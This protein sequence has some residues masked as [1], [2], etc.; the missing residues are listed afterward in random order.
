MIKVLLI[1]NY[2]TNYNLPIYELISNNPKIEL[3]ILHFGKLESNTKIKQI[4][5]P[6]KKYFIFYF[7][8][9]KLFKICKEFDVVISLADLHY[10]QLMFLSILPYKNFKLI[11]WTIGV[12]ASYKNKFD[13]SKKWD[14]F[15]RLFYRN[16]DGLLFYSDY[17]INKY[18]MHGFSNRKLF[19]APNTLKVLENK[20]QTHE[21]SSILFIGTLYY[22]KGIFTLLEAYNNAFKSFMEYPYKLVIIGDGDEKEN[23]KKWIIDNKQTDNVLLKGAIF[24]E[25]ILMEYFQKSLVCVSP[26]QAG[27]SVLKSMGYGVPFITNRNAI[28]GGEI[29]NIINNENGILYN[30]TSELTNIL[31]ELVTNPEKFHRMGKSAHQFYLDNRKPIHMVNGFFAAIKYVIES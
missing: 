28:T 27:L 25:N 19:V 3:T 8:N 14:Y 1:Q 4:I 26:N 15:R 9:Y 16:A 21:K 30:E 11:Y 24:N 17:P 7:T 13:K 29:F 12:S 5:L 6:E 31:I 20:F 23:I 2:I 10:P 18:L 22:E